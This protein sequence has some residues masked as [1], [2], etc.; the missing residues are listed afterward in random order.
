MHARQTLLW[1][2]FCAIAF[3]VS[4]LNAQRPTIEDRVEVL[5][6]HVDDLGVAND[7]IVEQLAMLKRQ[8]EQFAGTGTDVVALSDS[9]GQLQKKVDEVRRQVESQ[10]RTL[11]QI[12]TQYRAYGSTPAKAD[13]QL[14]AK[15]ADPSILQPPSTGRL[16]ISN[17]M[18][19]QQRLSVNGTTYHLPALSEVEISVP[20]GTATTELNGYE[21]AK[22]WRIGA[23]DY[24]QRI[25]IRPAPMAP[26]VF[27]S[28]WTT[29][30]PV[31]PPM[32]SP[33][34]IVEPPLVPSRIPYWFP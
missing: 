28:T 34:I 23:P 16:R 14:R 22:V 11:D 3:S 7:S 12:Q 30:R 26:P 8:M 32:A 27:D 13:Q 15:I 18:T 21:A 1:T 2:L 17:Q 6:K 20:V 19:T 25:D 9:L 31:A 24:Q 29:L 10:R 4:V 33:T 5:E